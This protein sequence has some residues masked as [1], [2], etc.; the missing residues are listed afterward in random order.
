MK[1]KFSRKF[2]WNQFVVTAMIVLVVVAG[3]MTYQ[4]SAAGKDPQ[5]FDEGKESEALAD[6]IYEGDSLLI[7]NND[8]ESNDYEDPGA[9]ILVSGTSDIVRFAAEVKLTREQTRA[10]SKETLLEIIE[11]D[12][13]EEASKEAAAAAMVELANR[14]E[15]ENA[16]ESLLAAKG[17]ENSIVSITDDGVNVVVDMSHMDDRMIAQIEDIVKEK[18]GVLVTQ[19]T[20]TPLNVKDIE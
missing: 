1:I 6:Q 17:F 19:M 15:R 8:I 4:E 20:I 9:S 16:A 18:T 5:S 14:I 13:L 11:N 10:K 3:Y 12:G 2:Q 7:S